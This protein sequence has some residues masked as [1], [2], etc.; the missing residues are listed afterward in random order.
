MNK[1]LLAVL[2][3]VITVFS[4]NQIFAQEEDV[5][6]S[7]GTVKSISSSRIIVTEYD[8]DNNEAEVAY[9]VDPKVELRGVKTLKDIAVGDDL[10]IEYVIRGG[11]KVAKV[12]TVEKAPDFE[13]E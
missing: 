6:Y 11:K 10:D 9:A 7:W 3:C 5:E 1:W 4:S 8:Y 13:F 2:I 12:L